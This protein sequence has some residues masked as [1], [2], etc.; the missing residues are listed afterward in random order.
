MKTIVQKFGGSSLATA[1]LRELAVSRVLSAR[2]RGAAPVVVCSAMG[3][4]A[5]PYSTDALLALVGQEKGSRNGDLLLACGET[6]ACV[7]LAQLL[8][9]RGADAVALTGAQAG[10]ITD[11]TFGHARILRVEPSALRSTLERGVIAVVA[12]FQGASEDGDTTTLGRGGSDLSAIALGAA[13]HADVVEVFTDVPGVMTADPRRVANAHPLASAHYAEVAE[14]A[15]DG[16]KVM[17]ADAAHLARVTRTPYVIKGLH[18]NFGTT[19]DESEPPEDRALVAGIAS[20]PGL[21]LVAIP[22][23]SHGDSDSLR[24]AIFGR[25]AARGISL[26]MINLSAG[27]MFFT[28]ADAC[29]PA[30]RAVLGDMRVRF[31]VHE[32]CA[33][34]SLV[35]A[36]MRGAPGVVTRIIETL[37][38]AGID[39]LHLTDSNITV[40]LLTSVD[41]LPRAEQA[42]HDAFEL[43]REFAAFP[44]LS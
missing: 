20:T 35:G 23:S 14:L 28:V 11:A 44:V 33:K 25:L 41:D 24:R 4:A 37:A 19:I 31:E 2:A 38:E 16:A 27:G 3:R 21:A 42:L 6:I 34:L 30:I 39:V 15:A 43:D 10:I 12:G 26:D 13:L 17:H 9:E 1:E 7:V 32:R 36:G 29:V 22:A 8:I 5:D 40:S 18:A